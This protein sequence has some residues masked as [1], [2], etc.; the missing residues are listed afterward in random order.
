[1]LVSIL[2]FLVLNMDLLVLSRLPGLHFI[3][4]EI[5]LLGYGKILP[6]HVMLLPIVARMGKEPSVEKKSQ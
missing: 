2:W 4:E 3:M 5:S 6:A 1:M